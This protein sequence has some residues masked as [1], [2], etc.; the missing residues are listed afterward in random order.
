MRA[1]PLTKEYKVRN[2]FFTVYYFEGKID[3]IVMQDE[4]NTILFDGTEIQVN[5]LFEG[6]QEVL[7][8]KN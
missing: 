6:V 5:E 4:D 2:N 7:N 8:D 1:I 3:R